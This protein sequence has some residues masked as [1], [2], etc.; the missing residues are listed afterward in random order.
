MTPERWDRICSVFHAAREQPP[1]R[2]EEFLREASKDDPRLY[3]EVVRMLRER[4]ST[5]PLDR[6]P[7]AAALPVFENHQLVDGRFKILRYV[8][9]GGMGEVYEARD[10]DLDGELQETVALKTLLP[11]IAA[12]KAMISRFMREIALS[13]KVNHPNV[14]N[15]HDLAKH[16]YADGRTVFFLTMEF[17]AGETLQARLGAAGAMSPTEAL[18]LLRQ[19]AAALEA[20]HV[21]GV[22]HRDF[23][24]PN[25]ILVPS[26]GALRAVVTDFGLARPFASP[27]GPTVSMSIA[28]TLEYMAPE[29][30]R[31]AEATVSS[32]VYAL[33]MTAYQMV[34]GRLPF[35]DETPMAAAILRCQRPVPAPRSVVPG[36]SPAWDSAIMRALEAD[37]TLRFTGPGDFIQ[38][39]E[40]A[41]AASNRPPSITAP[42][43]R[44]PIAAAIAAVLLAGA[45]LAWYEWRGSGI[46]LPPAAQ[47]LYEQ[48]ADDN[49]A[50]AYFAATQALEEAA[51]LAPKSP[52]IHAKLAEAWVALDAP[53]RGASEM[54]LVR[55]ENTAGLPAAER[56]QIEA[57]DLSITQEYA[58]AAAKY[59]EMVKLLPNDAD[60]LVDL[61][62]AYEG[63]DKPADA[64]RSYLRAAQGPRQSP[65]AW[66]RLAVLYS[67]GPNQAQAAEAFDRAQRLYRLTSRLEGLTEVLLQRGNAANGTGQLDRAADDLKQALTMAR[68]EGNIQEEITATLRLSQNAYLAG[69]A[70]D[71]DR[72]AREALDTAQRNHFDS[73]AVRGLINMGNAFRR[74]Q[75]YAT[76]EQ[77]YREALDLARQTRSE[78]MIALSL[79]SLAA[80]HDETRRRDE[81]LKEAK[82][83]LPFYQS[84]HYAK[85][86]LQ[87]MT[88]LVRLQRD[89]GDYEGA[90]ASAR[91]LL[92]SAEQGG[93]R[94]QAHENVGTA[95]FEMDRYPEAVEEYRK[96]VQ[97]ASTP[98]RTG[99]SN[100]F[101]GNTLWRLGNYSEAEAAFAQVD[102][103]VEKFPAIRLRLSE[104]RGLMDLS[105]GRFADA[106]AL[107]SRALAEG[108]EHSPLKAS[109]DELL[110][111]ALAAQ[112]QKREAVKACERARTALSG[113]DV[114]D[115]LDADMAT[116]QV[117]VETGAS[118]DALAVFTEMQPH[119]AQHPEK[120]WRALALASMADKKFIAPARDALAKIAQTWG[121]S[122]YNTYLTRPDIVKLSGRLRQ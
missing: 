118:Q 66:L 40:G 16:K 11:A 57:I 47:A 14:C 107:A 54:L 1:S 30:L 86:T 18:P 87:V 25:V 36:L 92:K 81:E 64:M 37:R 100:L 39:L 49:A 5:G 32:D 65:A 9:R 50:G 120:Q 43:I 7:D 82:E 113:Q 44:K 46:A 91:E 70:A 3:D 26:G 38:A 79:F 103:V 58:A 10:L 69:N 117:Q 52:Q 88:M 76:A 61:G 96:S 12:D 94:A 53:E 15:V 122:A 4:E 109:L 95:L 41:P 22:I 68:T 112:G 42:F 104:G 85:E 111:L 28:G 99:W 24:P 55:R 63:A 83:A 98:E 90:L 89:A 105:R 108:G 56:L 2:L 110:G 71:A 80:L 21:A 45:A 59:E 19:M 34:T 101:L 102:G 93:D 119:L 29:L 75:D 20:C 13:R 97:F 27:N 116:L 114:S 60:A 77:H 8:G 35:P 48:G 23:K 78:H 6:P 51:K 73:L 62:R 106:A 72:Y 121:D 67:R 84:N 115:L 74:R 33:G 17:L 31:G